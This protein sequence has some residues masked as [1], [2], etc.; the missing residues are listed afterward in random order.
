MRLRKK[1]HCA[2][3]YDRVGEYHYAMELYED[4]V[5]L[6]GSKTGR[7]YRYLRSFHY[8]TPEEAER[9]FEMLKKSDD[10][11]PDFQAE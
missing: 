10:A 1:A 4:G 11:N 7:T 5:W 6:Y 2:K 3:Y 9:L 8:D